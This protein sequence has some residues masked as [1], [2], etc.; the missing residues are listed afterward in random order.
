MK[1]FILKARFIA[2]ISILMILI[3]GCVPRFILDSGIPDVV[4][5]AQS[6]ATSQVTS[7]AADA[8][9]VVVNDYLIMEQPLVDQTYVYSAIARME[10][11]PSPAT[12]DRG[13]FRRLLDD[14]MVW[15][16]HYAKTRI[17]KSADL[18]EEN[19]I[20][21]L[22]IVDDEGIYRAPQ[23]LS[24]SQSNWWYKA[25]VTDISEKHRGFLTVSGG[26]RVHLN[27]IRVAI[28]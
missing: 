25:R 19:E 4:V 9:Y 1:K 2:A 18:V 28:R 3:S 21:F 24:E 6:P 10:M 5:V 27:A 22:N 13:K 11:A 8:H 20:F 23:S 7:P 15:T 16:E 26:F 14:Q 12:N 17:A